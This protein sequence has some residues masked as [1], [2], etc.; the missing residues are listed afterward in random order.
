MSIT[1]SI[2]SIGECLKGEIIIRICPLDLDFWEC[3]GTRA[4]L[5][6]EGV[7]PNGTDWLKSDIQW[8]S[9]NFRYWLWRT[10]P[11]GIK[12][13][14]KQSAEWD[15][16]TL[17]CSLNDGVPYELRRIE[18]KKKMLKDEIYRYSPQGQAEWT[19]NYMRAMEAEKDQD[20]QKFKALIPGCIRKKRG[21]NPPMASVTLSFFILSN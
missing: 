1:D 20:F 13:T 12:G 7:I 5:E 18:K 21:R 2:E 14:I 11:S 6:A 4:Q 8:V 17:R 19:A 16:W 3:Q 15:W 9:E 10:R